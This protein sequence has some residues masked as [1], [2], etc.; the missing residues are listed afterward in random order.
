MHGKT[1]CGMD[2]TLCRGARAVLNEWERR[3]R[4][5]GELGEL[6]R[7]VRL[8]GV[9]AVGGQ[10]GERRAA[11]PPPGALEAQHPRRQLGRRADLLDEPARQ[12]PA[13]AAELLRQLPDPHAPAAAL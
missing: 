11:E 4:P 5:P 12:V 7:E 2:R 6:A 3:R 13:R 10:A 1:V 8:V 9:A